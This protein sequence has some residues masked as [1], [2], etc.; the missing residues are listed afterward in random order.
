MRKLIRKLW[1]P[2][3]LTAAASLAF[4]G[5]Q[6]TVPKSSVDQY[7]A[8]A[9]RDGVGVG[10][11]LLPADEVRKAFTPDITRCC[12]VVEVALFPAKDKPLDVSLDE[13]TMR[14]AGSDTLV[15]PMSART[16]AATVQE[17]GQQQSRVGGDVHG[18]VGYES[19]T[20]T[21]PN[22][23]Q[24][25]KVQGVTT[26][27]GADVGV[28]PPDP[29]SGPS[30]TSRDNLETLLKEK[31]LAE[32]SVSVPVAGYVYF[33]KSVRKKK[34]APLELDYELKDQTVVL[35]LP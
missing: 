29:R 26:E 17:Q 18:G 30:N 22:T 7:R 33:P 8:H 5:S 23:G 31:G 6:G 28:A 27:A 35:T 11:V 20:Y 1:I 14:A 2:L 13:L 16:V 25:T 9:E 10:A 3:V 12:L 4:A 15:H 34:N 32:G 19:G 24:Q 21:D